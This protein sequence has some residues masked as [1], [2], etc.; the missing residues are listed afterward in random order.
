MTTTPSP[1]LRGVRIAG[2][3]IALPQRVVTNDD[4]AQRVETSDAWISQRTGI[5]QRY[6]CDTPAGTREMAI[7]ATRHALDNAGLSPGDLDLLILATITAE[8]S[9]P[10]TAARVVD[11]LGATP[12]GAMDVVAACSGFVYGMNLASSL[13]GAGAYRRVAVVGAEQLSRIVNWEDR[14]TCVLFG[15]GAGAA[16][17]EASDREPAEQGC[18]HQ[19]M[20]SDGGGWKWLSVPTAAEG[21]AGLADA[22]AE[23]NGR[24]DT[25]HMNGRE[26]YKFAVSTLKKCIE[27][28]LDAAGLGLD[29]LAMIVCHQ[30][31]AR[32][33]ESAR[34]RLGLPEG[35]LYINID[36]YANTSAA[37][38]PLCLAELMQQGQLQPD[39]G[40]RVLFVA[41][42]GG[43][44]WTTSL[45]RL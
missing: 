23:F 25:M 37:S 35:K 3:G 28:A 45:W 39:S 11:E 22:G 43:L 30:S 5:R 42:G 13:I 27:Q 38:V 24:L 2:T 15:D 10:S 44:T 9:C 4:L 7:Q 8:T 18:L 19:T 32:I 34:E 14:G 16:I 33:L 31:N 12:A 29:D 1:T 41:M 26:V 21:E 40:Q 17:F 36:R 20:H 6:I